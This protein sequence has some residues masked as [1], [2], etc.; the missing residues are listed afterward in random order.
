MADTV[1][2][3]M[4]EMIPE[5]R[6]LEQKGI[7][8]KVRS[9]LLS[10]VHFNFT[11]D[12]LIRLTSHGMSADTGRHLTAGA[13]IGIEFLYR[14]RSNPLSSSAKSSSTLSSAGS[15]RRL[16]FSVISSMR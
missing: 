3:Y 7:F 16:T 4:E 14:Q 1:Q 9:F 11:C 15:A 8:S 12:S 10:F 6:D 2:F 5:M 13:T